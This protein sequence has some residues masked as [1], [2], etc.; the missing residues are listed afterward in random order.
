MF[1]SP[2]CPSCLHGC[3]LSCVCLSSMLALKHTHVV[4]R[5]DTAVFNLLIF[6]SEFTV[7]FLVVCVLYYVTLN[8]G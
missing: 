1:D 3:T 5:L 2:F 4:C 8:S 6:A 7:E